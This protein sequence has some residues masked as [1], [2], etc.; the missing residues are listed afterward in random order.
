MTLEELEC[1][2]FTV[3]DDFNTYNDIYKIVVFN[4]RDSLKAFIRHHYNPDLKEFFE[5]V[6]VI[7]ANEGPMDAIYTEEICKSVVD[8]IFVVDKNLLAVIIDE[9]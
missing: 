7:T 3:L 6:V 2:L 5:C 8:G 9:E 1:E 4:N